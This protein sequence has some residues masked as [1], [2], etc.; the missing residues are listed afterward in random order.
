MTTPI[1]APDD[2]RR[3]ASA[4]PP[5]GSR[6]GL[7]TALALGALAVFGVLV[8]AS[9]IVGIGIRSETDAGRTAITQGTRQLSAG[10]LGRALEHFETAE[11]RFASGA[12]RASEGLGGMLARLPVLG[13]SFDVAAGVS[14]AGAMLAGAGADLTR[15]IAA[16]PGGLGALAP[17]EGRLPIDPLSSLAD[18]VNRAAM[19]AR[20]AYET[21][22]AT[23]STLIPAPVADTRFE[24]EEQAAAA[25]RSLEAA[26][27]IIEGMP[28]FAGA[29]G[30]RRY[31]VIAESPSEQRGTGGLGGAYAIMTARDGAFTI[32]PF[33]PILTLP[34]ARPGQV[35][36]PNPD[37]GSNWDSYGGAGSW[38]DLNMTPDFPSAA[39]AI[40]SL[41]EFGTGEGLDGVIVADP[42]AVKELFRVTGPAEIPSLGTR[43]SARTVVDFLSNE[44][45]VL[46]DRPADR[47]TL[48]GD[49]VGVAFGEF[50]SDRGQRVR[51]VDAIA[52]AVAGG[53]LKIYPT[54]PTLRRGLELARLDRGLRAPDGSDLLAVH[55]NS[56]SGSKVD[57]YAERSIRYD[58]LLGGE[59]EA[60][61]T[62]DI[63][64]SNDAPTGGAPRYVIGPG[65]GFEGVEPGDNVSIVTA[66][67]PSDC[68]LIEAERN[69][70]DQAMRVN[71]ELGRPRYQD[72]FTT[73]GGERSTLKIVTHRHDV[74]AGDSSGG[75]YRLT[76]LPQVTIQPTRLEVV[77]RPPA[78]TNVVWASERVTLRDGMA[79]W[80]GEPEGRLDLV[81][82]FRAR[83]PLRW[84]RN[85]T[86][87]LS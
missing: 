1:Q 87:A 38:R 78:G 3:D 68:E 6:R 71:E 57:F 40:L 29:N 77:I 70:R 72:Y 19:E 55:V 49:V 15:S 79:I 28:A 52:H 85:L 67:C 22:R 60:I 23:P 39:R 74:W 24:A 36:A 43:V 32:G 83:A 48:L 11:S 51:K 47:K 34:E 69:G 12:D 82:R 62:T 20:A 21:I 66:S 76:V 42:F 4:P 54:D 58:V 41:Y 2:A 17:S 81:F 8:I 61:A 7:L 13:R 45:Y 73:G 10:E 30:P 9:A 46:F 16:I 44:A 75:V 64:I 65:K 33:S 25:S 18:D 80:R 37:F 5:A 59:G 31:I 50:L 86:N 14:E 26:S 63:A 35:P 84:W 27:L 53:H 56:R